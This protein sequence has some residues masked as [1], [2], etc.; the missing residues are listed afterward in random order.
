MNQGVDMKR[1]LA[2][3][4]LL[5]ALTLGLAG[6]LIVRG[7]STGLGLFLWICGMVLNIALLQRTAKVELIKEW[8]WMAGGAVVMGGIFLWRES[9]ALTAFGLMATAG[10]LV[11]MTLRGAKSSLSQCGLLEYCHGALVSG[12]HTVAGAPMLLFSDVRW[13]EIT[14]RK[15]SRRAAEVLRGLAI[16]VPVVVVLGSLLVKA[17]AVFQKM[18]FSIIDIDL[19]TLF[20]HLFFIGSLTWIVAGFL[21]GTFLVRPTPFPYTQVRPLSLGITEVAIVLSSAIV[22][23]AF[24]MAVEFRYFFGGADLVLVTPSL[25]YAEYARHGFFELTTVVALVLPML[26]VL[27]WLLKKENADHVRLFRVLAVIQVAL[28]F[29]VAGSAVQRM[30]LYQQ[31]YG[32]TELRVYTTAFIGWMA[33]L[34]LWYVT[35]VLSG[36]RSLFA[37]GAVGGAFVTILILVTLN[38]DD[39]I[40]RTNIA[41]AQEGKQVDARYL[42]LL[43][44]D[45]V[46]ALVEGLRALDP[47][48]RASVAKSL[49]RRRERLAAADWRSW[50]WSS[51]AASRALADHEEDLQSAAVRSR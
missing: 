44:N 36:R 46:P 17:D 7:S 37:I 45:A 9:D 10:A 20:G 23:F 29:A 50:N 42:T 26:L 14:A 13:E 24:F 32:L 31:E 48:S 16:A 35:T 5:V 25:T 39:L 18:I 2:A 27:D 4:I 43:S 12:A 34:L 3:P 40:A 19:T 33:M 21:R 6:D 11:L 15:G 1:L 30:F 49:L 47:E 51:Y 41:R 28:L 38:P 8:K 22:L